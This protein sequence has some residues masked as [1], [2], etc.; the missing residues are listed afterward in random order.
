MLYK[1]WFL[2]SW[3][4]K[5]CW[6]RLDRSQTCTPLPAAL[7]FYLTPSSPHTSTVFSWPP[8][9]PFFIAHTW[10]LRVFLSLL[11]LLE[12]RKTL[13]T[14]GCPSPP[15]ADSWASVR[16]GQHRRASSSRKEMRPIY[17]LCK[18]RGGNRVPRES[19]AGT[20]HGGTQKKQCEPN[21]QSE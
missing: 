17:V 9:P 18:T 13:R 12:T 3:T 4:S 2:V 19:F 10:P 15:A 7:I 14:A 8:P 6:W 20:L 1:Q 11:R 5:A 16:L 21:N